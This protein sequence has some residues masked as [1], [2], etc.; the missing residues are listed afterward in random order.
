VREQRVAT[1]AVT[2]IR[3]KL[4]LQPCSEQGRMERSEAVSFIYQLVRVSL[5]VILLGG[6]ARQGTQGSWD[7]SR[8]GR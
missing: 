7:H 8:P 2:L 3:G 1:S 4:I 5:S 6:A